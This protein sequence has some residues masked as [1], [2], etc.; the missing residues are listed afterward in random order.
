MA[1]TARTVFPSGRRI[2]KTAK[3]RSAETYADSD[4]DCQNTD[5]QKEKIDNFCTLFVLPTTRRVFRLGEGSASPDK[6]SAFRQE[7]HSSKKDAAC[8]PQNGVST[9]NRKKD[10]K[11]CF[12]LTRTASAFVLISIRLFPMADAA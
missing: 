8:R 9:P 3:K 4:A 6:A 10:R 7:F 2:N 5:R 1:L 12:L 11:H